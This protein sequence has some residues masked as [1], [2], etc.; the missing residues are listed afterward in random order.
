[1]DRLKIYVASSWRCPTQPIVVEALRAA[2]HDVYDFRNPPNKS[3]FA[4]SAVAPWYT[5]GAVTPDEY[6]L[7][8]DNPIAEAGFDADMGA[9]EGCD[10]CVL[11]LPCGRSAHMEAGIAIGQGKPVCILLDVENEPELMYRAARVVSDLG[12]VLAWAEGVVIDRETVEP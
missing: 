11:V 8:V 10:V 4:W 6:V 5:G 7:M 9:L 2:G 3:G 1:M 12:E